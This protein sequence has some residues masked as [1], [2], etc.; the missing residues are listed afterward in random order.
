MLLDIAITCNNALSSRM[1]CTVLKVYG[2]KTSRAARTLWMCRELGLEFGQVPVSFADER[3]KTPE[4]FAVNPLGKMPAIDDDGFHLAESMAINI[5]LAKKHHSPLFPKDLTQEALVLQWSFWV[6]SEIEKPLLALMLQ[7]MTPPADPLVAK[8]FRDRSPPDAKV[9]QASVEALQKPLKY[10]DAHLKSREYL[11]G[12][13]FTL[14]DLNVA[15]VMA[16]ARLAKLDMT[17]F[18]NADRW[19][20]ACLARPAARG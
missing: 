16:W 19:L 10:F 9:E 14:A 6:M 8:F 12:S 15:S 5:Y 4:F 2:I 11:L 1:R 20:S 7:R 18:P 13:Q 17:A 3:T